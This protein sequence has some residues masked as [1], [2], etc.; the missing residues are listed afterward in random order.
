MLQ[1]SKDTRHAITSSPAHFSSIRQQ[2]KSRDYSILLHSKLENALKH[3]V[4]I[5]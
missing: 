5:D 2:Q 4:E 1:D 3:W